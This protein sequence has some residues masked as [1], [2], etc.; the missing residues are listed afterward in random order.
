M[1]KITFITWNQSKAD[2][3]SKYLWFDVNYIKIDLEEIQ[4]LDLNKIVEY[5]LKQAYKLIKKPVI[6]EDVSLEFQALGWLPWPF[7]KFFIENNDFDTICWMINWKNRKAIAKCVLWYF[8]WKNL[9][10]FK[11]SLS[12]LIAEEQS[13]EYW[14]GWDKI[15]I[16]KWYDVT[17]ASLSE[18]DDKKTYLELK[19]FFQL[20]EYLKNLY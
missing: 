14:F 9:K 1:D 11:W 20:K 8:D 15:F 13:W 17:R 4:S 5:K 19:P 18:N 6:V 7:I 12:W 10:L 2:Y 16:P 3:L